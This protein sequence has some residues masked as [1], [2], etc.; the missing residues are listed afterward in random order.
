MSNFFVG[1]IQTTWEIK[2]SEQ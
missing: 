2:E 1:A